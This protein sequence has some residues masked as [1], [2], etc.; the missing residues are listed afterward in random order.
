M[1][2]GFFQKRQRRDRRPHG[3]PGK[4]CYA[5]GDIHGRLDLL[6]ELLGRIEQDN[7]SRAPKDVSIVLVGD[8]VD[9]GP[10]SKGVVEWAMDPKVDFA[11]VY[12]LMGNHEELMVRCLGGEVESL[13]NWLENGG[14]DCVKSYGVEVGAL[15]GQDPDWVLSQIAPL[16][17]RRHLDFLSSLP[18]SV[19]FGDY[20]LVHAGI[21]PGVPIDRQSKTDLHWIRAEFLDSKADHGAVVVHGHTVTE[22]IE[23]KENRI[24]ID[25][26]AYKTGILTAVRLEDADREF[27]QAQG[28]PGSG[29]D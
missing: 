12:T 9:R 21:R 1:L 6:R 20:L 11:K 5:I 18:H 17:P 13:S 7:A 8:L 4:R 23:E 22:K 27:I 15:Y 14:Y 2:G 24:G 10:N 19:R 26:G 29:Y 25:T 28:Q 16:I 3:A